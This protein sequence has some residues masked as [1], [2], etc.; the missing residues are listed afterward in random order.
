MTAGTGKT[1]SGATARIG[2]GNGGTRRTATAA[3]ERTATA[4]TGT[5]R[6]RQEGRNPVGFRPSLR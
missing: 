3:I 2:S 5:A 6:P 4:A 1:G